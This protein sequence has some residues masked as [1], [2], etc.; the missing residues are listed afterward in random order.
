MNKV[1]DEKFNR[2]NLLL[3]GDEDLHHVNTQIST[4]MNAGKKASA[5]GL[6]H[7]E[8]KVSTLGPILAGSQLSKGYMI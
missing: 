1:M 3:Q 2:L 5:P 8:T 6:Q 7:G 4:R